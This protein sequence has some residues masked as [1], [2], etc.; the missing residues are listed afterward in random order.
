[1]IKQKSVKQS[2]TD[3]RQKMISKKIKRAVKSGKFNQQAQ[4]TPVR[5]GNKDFGIPYSGK[6]K[7]S[8]QFRKFDDRA[9]F[10]ED[11]ETVRVATRVTNKF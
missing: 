11:T 10:D 8:G 7:F 1:M 9:S 6:D 5:L 3:A 4:G 2:I